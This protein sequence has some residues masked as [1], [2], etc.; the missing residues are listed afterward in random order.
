MLKPA[1]LFI[2]CSL[3]DMCDTWYANE[4]IFYFYCG[5]HRI[6]IHKSSLESSICYVK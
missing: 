3:F 4:L 5:L 1:S 6:S 2:Y